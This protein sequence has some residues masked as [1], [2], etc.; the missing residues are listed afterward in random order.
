MRR[1]FSALAASLALLAG[2]AQALDIRPGVYHAVSFIGSPKY[3]PDAR[4]LDTVNPNAPK[5]GLLRLHETGG[6]DSLNPFIARGEAAP[7]LTL[8]YETLMAT[9]PGDPNTKYGLL[10]ETIDIAPD[11]GSVVFTL[12]RQ[13]R[14]PNGEPVTAHDAVYSLETLKEKGAP[15]FRFYYA[16]VARAEALDDRRVRFVFSDTTNRELPLI[17]GDLPILQKSYWAARDVSRTTLEPWQGSG[18]YRI[19]RTETNRYIEYERDPNYWGKDLFLNV[20]RHNFDRIRYDMFRDDTVALQAFKAR[21]YDFRQEV[22][23]RVWFEGYD[24][25]GVRQG[26]VVRQERT[27]NRGAGLNGFVM[28]LRRPLFQDQRVRRALMLTFDYELANRS[29]FYGRYQRTSSF[30]ENSELAARGTPGP[31]ELKYLEPLRDRLP[32]SVFGPDWNP[33]VSDGT[34]RDRALLGQAIA[35]LREAGWEMK[36]G[37]MRNAQGQPMVIEFL[38]AQPNLERI[39]LMWA[40]SLEAMGITLRLR[41]VDS[42]QYA[43]R[44][45]A[46]DYDMA[47]LGWGQSESPGNEQR[48]FWSS[49]A[50]NRSGSRNWM[51][52][53]DPAVD[54]LIEKLIA[55]PNRAELV[56]ATR[57][58]DR[59]LQAHEFVIPAW[60]ISQDWI[61]YWDQFGIPDRQPGE[62]VDMMS[63]WF[64]PAKAARLPQ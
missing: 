18:P 40:R 58:L 11:Y 48:E 41:S 22:T 61:A 19:V 52:L 51:G 63:W 2:A 36:N 47:R 64:D 50:A 15:L 25:A 49:A 59:V 44:V 46:W 31:D 54:A 42:A 24:F 62:G 20:G 16:N 32:A 38:Y 4:H 55:A 6:F 21:D 26:L 13:A 35:L 56:A 33:P 12:R 37:A 39:L 34:G 3:G 10:A 60:H 29:F 9:A 27:H 43:A 1:L 7:G 57:A 8:V 14:W 53:A 17:M 5:G 45:R 30:F 28:N 23:A